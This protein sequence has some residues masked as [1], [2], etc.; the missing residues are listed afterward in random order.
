MSN[1]VLEGDFDS[2]V[3]LYVYDE[4]I[5]DTALSEIINTRHENV[6]YLPGIKLPNNLV[7]KFLQC[8]GICIIQN[9]FVLDRCK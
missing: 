1:N 5:R 6:K 2:R 3:H 8:F 7:R 9:I 4:M